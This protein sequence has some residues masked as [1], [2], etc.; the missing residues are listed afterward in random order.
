MARGGTADYKMFARGITD[1]SKHLGWLSVFIKFMLKDE[2]PEHLFLY[3]YKYLVFFFKKK[4][5][6]LSKRLQEDA[7][8]C[9]QRDDLYRTLLAQC[10]LFPVTCF[11]GYPSSSQV[12][13]FSQNYRYSCTTLVAHFCSIFHF[14]DGLCVISG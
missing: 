11:W 13:K 8:N 3:V 10:F 9:S 4:P 12:L 1:A 5:R 6:L 7:G 2:R 14:S